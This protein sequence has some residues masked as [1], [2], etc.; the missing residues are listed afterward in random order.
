MRNDTGDSK[1]SPY[2]LCIFVT[3]D[4]SLSRCL[5]EC[6]K[7]RHSNLSCRCL[8]MPM[9]E[10]FIQS[11]GMHSNIGG[12]SL[13]R[14]YPRMCTIVRSQIKQHLG[15]SIFWSSKH[16]NKWHSNYGF[17]FLGKGS[18]YLVSEYYTISLP[19]LTKVILKFL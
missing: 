19:T 5:N 13:N 16:H 12:R 10:T 6:F 4:K 11:I 9:F 18:L 1:Y 17:C 7:H 2:C 8:N 14:C 15:G 3:D